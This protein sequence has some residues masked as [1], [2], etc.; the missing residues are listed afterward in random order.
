MNHLDDMQEIV[1]GKLVQSIGEL[2]I[3]PASFA[4]LAIVRLAC[5]G[6]AGVV[7]AINRTGLAKNVDKVL[8]RVLEGD[9]MNILVL[10][11]GEVQVVVDGNLATLLGG[12]HVN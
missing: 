1:L 9:G 7:L 4:L 8:R 10:R 2:F 3:I 5:L 12:E 6:S 11:G